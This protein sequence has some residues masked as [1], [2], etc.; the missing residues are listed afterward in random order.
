MI[1]DR[2]T[3]AALVALGEAESDPERCDVQVWDRA[4]D[5]LLLRMGRARLCDAP[6]HED[7]EVVYHLRPLV[8][9][10]WMGQEF[11]FCECCGASDFPE[12]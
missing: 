7:T 11:N 10:L 1:Y 2:Q 12:A 3:A 5:N 8:L 6:R 9:R 4:H